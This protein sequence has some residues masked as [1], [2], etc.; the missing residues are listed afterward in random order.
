MHQLGVL[1]PRRRHDGD[2]RVERRRRVFR[3]FPVIGEVVDHLLD[4]HR[5]GLRQGALLQRAAREGIGGRVDVDREC[6]NR[7]LRGGFHGVGLEVLDAVAIRL[8]R[9]DMSPGMEPRADWSNIIAR[10]A[11]ALGIASM[12]ARLRPSAMGSGAGGATLIRASRWSAPSSVAANA[13]CASPPSPAA[14]RR[15]SWAGGVGQ[16]QPPGRADW[17]ATL[18][19]PACCRGAARASR[20]GR[21]PP[22]RRPIRGLAIASER[23]RR[24]LHQVISGVAGDRQRHEAGDRRRCKQFPLHDL[25]PEFSDPQRE[26]R[27]ASDPW[28]PAWIF[29]SSYACIAAASA[30]AFASARGAGAARPLSLSRSSSSTMVTLPRLN[31]SSAFNRFFASWMCQETVVSAHAIASAAAACESPSP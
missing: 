27:A 12:M 26:T 16:E 14:G 23:K 5:V 18:H 24:T 28:G 11:G 22:A 25:T 1:V 10:G 30:R 15:P 13:S 3:A 9:H 20:P 4:A 8:L 21:A 6:R 7:I 2:G 17:F 29:F 19:R 31:A